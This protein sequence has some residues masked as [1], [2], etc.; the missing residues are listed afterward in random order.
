MV[1]DDI[2]HIQILQRLLPLTFCSEEYKNLNLTLFQK[3]RG[4]K[5]Q[6]NMCC[7]ECHPNINILLLFGVNSPTL[8]KLFT[9][10]SGNLLLFYLF[11]NKI[12]N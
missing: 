3:S 5:V 11:E 10:H 2:I 7:G 1:D 8:N 4:R 6:K 9:S 12:Y